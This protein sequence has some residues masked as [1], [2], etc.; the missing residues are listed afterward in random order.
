MD[1]DTVFYCG[2]YVSAGFLE[3]V[4]RELREEDS[5]EERIEA[6]KRA[7]M[8]REK[9]AA[10]KAERI[11]EIKWNALFGLMMLSPVFMWMHWVLH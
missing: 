10:R 9:S 8:R 7:K 3:E 2:Y 5:R 6:R 1:E 4:K 11:S